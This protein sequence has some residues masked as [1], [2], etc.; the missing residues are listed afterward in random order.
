[1]EEKL[2]GIVLGG[3]NYGENDKILSIFT[4]EKGTVSARIKGVK[5]A[6]AKLKFASEPF[7][8]AEY[9]FMVNGLHRTV[10]T[11]SLIDSYYPIREDIVKY[12]CAGTILEFLR[13][14]LKEEIVSPEIFVL[15]LDTLKELA[16]G[17]MLPEYITTRFLVH[18]LQFTGYGLKISTSCSRCG[19]EK[20]TRP[21]FNADS[22][23]FTCGDCAVEGAR[24]VKTSTFNEVITAGRDNFDSQYDY[25]G[26]L[27]LIDFYLS[28]K[29]DEKLNSLKEL[30]RL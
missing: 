4:L 14:F 30:I 28:V 23:N 21:Y 11:A 18:A 13:K 22:G 15:A 3:V 25:K 24:E 7:C 6:G 26:S 1:M 17:D 29:T 20:I 9:V 10:K 12:F 16:Y 27:R 5:K 8:F 19:C 2:N